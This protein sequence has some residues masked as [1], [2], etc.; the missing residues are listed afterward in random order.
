MTFANPIMAAGVR[1]LQS[2]YAERAVTPVEATEAYLS[3]IRGLDGAL[4]C[5]VHV[6]AEGARAAA[7]ES[8]ARWHDGA[9]FS[10]STACPSR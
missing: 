10:P 4:G 8:A 6:D 2:L 9:A 3:R 5:Y 7:H 1:G